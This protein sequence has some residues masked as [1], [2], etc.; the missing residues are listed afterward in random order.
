MTLTPLEKELVCALT[1]CLV[2]ICETG[3]INNY[4]NLSD[5]ELGRAWSGVAKMAAEALAIAK[6]KESEPV[7]GQREIVANFFDSVK[8]S[9]FREFLKT[10]AVDFQN[11]KFHDWRIYA[12]A[13]HYADDRWPKDSTP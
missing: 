9:G 7:L 10:L 6:Q 1:Q 13:V 12:M 5:E 4:R 3:D 8:K 11:G 2:L